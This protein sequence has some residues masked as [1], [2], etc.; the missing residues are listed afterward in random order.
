MIVVADTSV[1][2]N[3]V[4]I[5]QEHTLQSL[6]GRVVIPPEVASEFGR[7]CATEA[8]FAG[9][10]LP[11][12]IEIEPAPNPIPPDVYAAKLDAGET[13]AI[14]LGLKLAADALLMDE[15]LGRLTAQRLGLKT[16]GILGVLADARRRG[17]IPSVR[18]VLSRLEV[19]AG[20]WIAPSLRHEVLRLAGESE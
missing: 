8:R 14:A 13:A 4:C 3:L 9:L 1:I 15:K 19:E 11:A 16:I 7:L 12:W 17:L 2:L 20:F 6:F 10:K 5:Q 18:A